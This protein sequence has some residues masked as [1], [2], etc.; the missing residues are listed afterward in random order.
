MNKYSI[1]D[2]EMDLLMDKYEDILTKEY[3]QDFE[4]VVVERFL[5][6]ME[7]Y[8]DKDSASPNREMW[9]EYAFIT[10]MQV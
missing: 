10:W 3:G 5:A 6:F 8:F 2:P 9:L 4:N 7:S 1:S